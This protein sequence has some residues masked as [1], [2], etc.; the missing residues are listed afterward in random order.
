MPLEFKVQSGKKT[1][2]IWLTNA[3]KDNED[4]RDQLKLLYQKYKRQGYLVITFQSGNENLTDL[5]GALLTTNRRRM[6]EQTTGRSNQQ[7]VSL[8][9]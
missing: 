6:A 5:T 9:M 1:V 8:S 3:E 2:E 4:L 7:T